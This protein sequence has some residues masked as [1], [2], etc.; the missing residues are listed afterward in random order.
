MLWALGLARSA[1]EVFML[2]AFPFMAIIVIAYNVVAVL[3]R[4]PL[5]G[6]AFSAVLPSGAAFTATTGDL[7]VIAALLLIFFEIV[8]ATNA[9]TSS[10]V[11]HGLS[12][13][14]LLVCIVEFLLVPGCGTTPFL[15]IT[16]MTLLDVVAGYSISIITARRDFAFGQE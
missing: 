10:I 7:L 16:L 14:V 15:L 1:R 5:D 12:M 6:V 13:L 3:L 8:T 4:R 11:N 2:R 9:R